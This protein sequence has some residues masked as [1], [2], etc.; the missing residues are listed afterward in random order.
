[1]MMRGSNANGGGS[2]SSQVMVSSRMGE[3]GK[4]HTEKYHESS[5]NAGNLRE[6]QQAYSNS[7]SGMDKM[8]LKR[9]ID[10][11]GRKMVRERNRHSG[12]E[13]QTQLLRGME[14]DHVGQFDQDWHAKAG[15]AGLQHG[16]PLG[17]GGYG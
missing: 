13:R 2:F 5:V 16:A 14:E 12:E 4:M 8:A 1:M 10:E 6:R 3:D 7:R 9:H 17:L 15:R 11:R